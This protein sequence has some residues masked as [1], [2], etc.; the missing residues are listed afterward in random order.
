M[1]KEQLDYIEKL[2]E[3]E[4]VEKKIESMRSSEGKYRE[5]Y[6][7][8]LQN[9]E[10][11]TKSY[12][13]LLEPSKSIN[14]LINKRKEEWEQFNNEKL[15]N[16]EKN[17]FYAKIR[18]RNEI[19]HELKKQI[20]YKQK[21]KYEEWQESLKNQ[22]F[23]K[24]K[25][26]EELSS[27]N[28]ETLR[29]IERQESLKKIYEKQLQEKR[30]FSLEKLRMNSREKALYKDLLNKRIFND[31]VAFPGVPGMH[32]KE[33]P[34]KFSYKRVYNNEKPARVYS[35]ENSPQKVRKNYKVEDYKMDVSKSMEKNRKINDYVF[36]DPYVH[37][38]IT[39]PLGSALPRAL[40]G[41]RIGKV[42]QPRQ[43]FEKPVNIIT[44]L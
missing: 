32:T 39:N 17:D 36:A 16:Q 42:S 30:S 40:P 43:Y 37:N 1:I 33:S 34:L 22:E 44:N 29:K 20:E 3:K 23:A 6:D 15:A 28:L 38:P 24:Y 26:F 31:P 13:P 25:A 11:K 21:Q 19:K 12:K 5:F 7:K 41:Q 8:R 9:L 2:R 18:S 10:E 14:D 35:N 27:K 4:L